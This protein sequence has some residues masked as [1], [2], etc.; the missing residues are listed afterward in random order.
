MSYSSFHTPSPLS[1]DDARS[2]LHYGGSVRMVDTLAPTDDTKPASYT[3][4]YAPGN[5]YTRGLEVTEYDYHGRATLT[6][7]L[8]NDEGRRW[9]NDRLPFM[10]WKTSPE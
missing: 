1:A 6:R 7:H 8:D 5:S 9:L 2:R 10:A 3:V 4:T